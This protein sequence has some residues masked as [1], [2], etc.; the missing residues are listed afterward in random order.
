MKSASYYDHLPADMV[1]FN[2]PEIPES[3]KIRA[4]IEIE[5]RQIQ[6]KAEEQAKAE[7]AHQKRFTTI[8]GW[9]ETAVNIISA[10]VSFF[11]KP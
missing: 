9:I 4:R 1:D 5:N 6:M 8:K 10:V 7:E 2:D 3:V 11:R